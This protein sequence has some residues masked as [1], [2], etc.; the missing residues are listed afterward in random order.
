MPA[1]KG[2]VCLQRLTLRC[3]YRVS[4]VCVALGCSERYLHEVFQRDV[5]LRPKDWMRRERMVV[6][7]RMLG[8]GKSPQD[9]AEAFG[10]AAG[11]SFCR[12]FRQFYQV[13]PAEYRRKRL[14]V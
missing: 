14:G 1:R 11:N 6:A 8:G 5:G 13:L 7:R 9:V 10:F 4:E 3:G 12:E 2:R